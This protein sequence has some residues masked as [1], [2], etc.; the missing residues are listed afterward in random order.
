[1]K[2][3]IQ[4]VCDFGRVEWLEVGGNSSKR[5]QNLAIFETIEEAESAIKESYLSNELSMSV[6]PLDE[7]WG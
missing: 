4:V 5:P 1:M 3:C 2:Y 7:Y 6:V